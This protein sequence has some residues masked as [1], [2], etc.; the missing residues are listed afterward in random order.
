M[1]HDH[2]AQPAGSGEYPAE[3]FARRASAF[4]SRAAAYAEY[5]PNY[6][7]AMLEWG[8]APVRDAQHLRVLDLGA[9]T[10]KLTEGL[11]ALGVPV[12]AVEPDSAM[13]AQLTERL[14]DVEAHVAKAESIP[15]PE[16]SVDAVFVGQALHWFDLDRA[17]PEIGRVLR[18]GGNLVA[19]WNTYNDDVEWVN[20]MVEISG[21]VHL[22][23]QMDDTAELEPLR[24]FG[25]VE[26]RTF[27]HPVKQ[28]VDSLLNMVST[29]SWV[30]VSPAG[31]RDRMLATL[32]EFLLAEPVT[33]DGEFVL[34]M[35]TVAMRV[36][37]Q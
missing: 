32:R 15:L 33:R 2:A 6:P 8:L 36:T 10:G 27:A 5:R 29:Q 34:P 31:E 25:D 16:A 37:P 23:Q 7:V 4:G 21:S 26:E 1:D 11:H 3:Q 30:L 17:L 20:R 19:A 24:E 18:P 13:L 22:S 35:V 12:V 14:P 28:T 9:G